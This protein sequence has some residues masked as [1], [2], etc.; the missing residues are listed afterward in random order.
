MTQYLQVVLFKFSFYI[1]ILLCLSYFIFFVIYFGKLWVFFYYSTFEFHDFHLWSSLHC[2]LWGW[3]LFLC[4]N[5]LPEWLAWNTFLQF[6]EI[7]DILD[8]CIAR[9]C[10]VL[11][12]NKQ[13]SYW[14]N[15]PLPQKVNMLLT[16]SLVFC[17]LTV[18]GETKLLFYIYFVMSIIFY[19]PCH[20]FLKM[21]VFS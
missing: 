2:F 6:V 9:F 8:L 5:S 16:S 14:H 3:Q 4:K 21:W 17:P 19:F 11:C 20:R 15:L 10:C 12:C 1:I 7:A 18:L 13:W